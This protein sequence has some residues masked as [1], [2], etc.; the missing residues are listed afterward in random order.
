MAIDLD[1]FDVLGAVSRSAPVFQDVRAD[2]GKYARAL[3]VAQ[4]KKRPDLASVRAVGGAVG[5]AAFSLIVD[6]MKD[7]EVKTLL[8]KLDKH[9][10]ELKAASP[11]WRRGHLRGLAAGAAEPT[12]KAVPVAKSK[13]K[14]GKRSKEPRGFL[15][16]E[17][18]AA[19]R[20]R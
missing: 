12:A 13:E 19:V 5:P 2:V 20:K 8:G 9:H 10:P 4:L 15:S 7:A 14:A 6:G 17:A 1:G 3:V 18:M 16:S 11:E